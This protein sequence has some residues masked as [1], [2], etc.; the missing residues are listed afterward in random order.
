MA[1]R[2]TTPLFDLMSRSQAS[3]PPPSTPRASKPVVRV[4][5]KPR[6][7][8]YAPPDPE[9]APEA[10]VRVNGKT[11]PIWI[12]SVV[13]VVALLALIAVWSLGSI[14]GKNRAERE[15]ADSLRREPPRIQE[16]GDAGVT[17]PLGAASTPTSSPA[18]RSPTNVSTAPRV[19]PRATSSVRA[20]G[21]ASGVDPRE[22][23][24][25]YLYLATLPRDDAAKAVDFLRQNGVDAHFLVV[26]SST[27]GANNAG[28]GACRVFVL[29]GF[30]RDEL[31]TTNAQ[32]L[33][34][35]V[36]RLGKVW[37]KD[38]RGSSNF[39]MP[40]WRKQQ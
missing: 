5:L 36:L 7:P 34:S 33:E 15:L 25:N 9:P 31:K 38:H 12:K 20:L 35:E 26:D 30:S 1:G 39:A 11:Y 10:V 23:G 27:G 19:E 18:L 28:P 8:S 16:P 40:E 6:E 21:P 37:Q 22:S 17:G 2:R 32:N 14:A 24:K 13:L 4:E 3:T 29:P